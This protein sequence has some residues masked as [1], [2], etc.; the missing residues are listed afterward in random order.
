MLIAPHRSGQANLFSLAFPANETFGRGQTVMPLLH[1]RHHIMIIHIPFIHVP[2]SSNE[3]FF[4]GKG[5]GDQ[6]LLTWIYH[7]CF[8]HLEKESQKNHLLL[9][10]FI[11][12]FLAGEVNVLLNNAFLSD[13]N[14]WFLLGIGVVLLTGF[15]LL[16]FERMV[17]VFKYVMMLVLLGLSIFQLAIFHSFPSVIQL[18]YLNLAMALIYI[19]G[20]LILFIG[21][22]TLLFIGFGHAYG[23]DLFFPFLDPMNITF[24]IFAETTLVLWAATRIGNSYHHID[25]TNQKMKQLLLEN[26]E[27][28]QLIERQNVIL[29]AYANQVEQLTLREERHRM[30][31]ELHDTVGHTVTSLILGMEMTKQIL[32]SNTAEA[33]EKLDSLIRTAR[34]GLS[35][36]RDNVYQQAFAHRISLTE[37]CERIAHEFSQ[38]TGTRIH[39][40]VGGKEEELVDS[41]QYVLIRCLQESLTNALRH[42]K[43][44]QIECRLH[45][46]PRHVKLSV[47]DNGTGCT[48]IQYGLGLTTMQ[49]R[50]RA[51]QGELDVTSMNGTGVSVFV[52]I[53]LKT[54]EPRQQIR[55]L[56][57]D[58]EEFIRES[59]SMLLAAESSISV[60]GTAQ[61]GQAGEALCRELQPDVILMDIHMPH[62][63]GVV[64]TKRIKEKWPQIKVIMLTTFGEIQFASEAINAGAEGY[65]I[66]SHHPQN[67]AKAVQLVY[68]GG[69]LISREMASILIS[70]LQKEAETPS[71]KASAAQFH[72]LKER[73]LQILRCLTQ[74]MRY[75]DI[76]AKLH[77]TEGTVRN[78][79]SSIY[80]K[81]DVHG[82]E[83]ATRI[84]REEGIV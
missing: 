32:A 18:L 7:K 16:R 28:V 50:V 47:M 13:S 24:G 22:L 60:V 40:S 48:H 63:D 83:E 71:P 82:R 77:L 57:V 73:E 31:R 68:S 27:Q 66:K 11:V 39:F 78:Y 55:V 15:A 42:G 37:Q 72:G 58:D 51:V 76:A 36:W 34:D 5:K 9:F 14:L 56:I 69:N 25:A 30:A 54:A 23:K 20:R 80:A 45:F 6:G 65:L 26:E 59:L 35:E 52:T 17:P 49:E 67:I 3:E 43:A 8:V 29:K 21:S 12:S 44:T 84:A 53:P 79:V 1:S 75:R 70:A 61:D 10:V 41:I 81:L 62:M 33:T 64:T 4:L 38:N 74:G 19:K 46:A 2:Y